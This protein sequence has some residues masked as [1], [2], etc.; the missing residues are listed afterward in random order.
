MEY[1]CQSCLLKTAKLALNLKD[2]NNSPNTCICYI[3]QDDPVGMII[4]AVVYI[5]FLLPVQY[6]TSPL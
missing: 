2:G 5:L 1:K 3:L 6:G 4:M